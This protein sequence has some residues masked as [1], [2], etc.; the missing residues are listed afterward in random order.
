MEIVLKKVT[1][2]Q[3]LKNSISQ[4]KEFY[5]NEDYNELIVNGNIISIDDI[6]EPINDNIKIELED[7]EL[8]K[9]LPNKKWKQNY[10]IGKLLYKKLIGF[11]E[12]QGDILDESFW[13]YLTHI[14]CVKKYIVKRYFSSDN[15]D[16]EE[17]MR[18][19]D[20]IKRYFFGEGIV[21]RTG[22]IFNYQLTNCLYYKN[23]GGKSDELCSIAFSFIDSV[24]AIYERSF[25]KNPLIVKAFV[26][27]I[28]RNN[29]SRA[30]TD[31][32]Y[33]TL[34]PTHISNVAALNCFDAYTYRDLVEKITYEQQI[35]IDEYN[36]EKIQ[37]ND[38]LEK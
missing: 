25:R 18:I 6:S 21:S 5:L 8:T 26:E 32:K 7:N 23:I 14:P 31:T 37:I 15:E 30:F 35:L 28:I 33:R 11:V 10:D 9:Y 13:V 3:F 16:D 27:G 17:S 4:N 22:I 12:I 34:I 38:D 1:E 36:R 20:K 24:K 19:I 29:R 2:L